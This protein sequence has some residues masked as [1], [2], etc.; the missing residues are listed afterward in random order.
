MFYHI[1]GAGFSLLGK[2]ASIGLKYGL[3][4]PLGLGL[5]YGVGMVDLVLLIK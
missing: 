5:K 3:M 4:K 2:P 1:L